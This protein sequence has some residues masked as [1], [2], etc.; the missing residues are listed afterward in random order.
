M[1]NKLF[2]SFI[3]SLIANPWPPGPLVPLPLDL[4][5]NTQKTCRGGCFLCWINSFLYD[6]VVTQIQDTVIGLGLFSSKY[7]CPGDCYFVCSIIVNECACDPIRQICVQ[8]QLVPRGI[9]AINQISWIKCSLIL[10]SISKT[11]DNI[12]ASSLSPFLIL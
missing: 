12:F 3:P 8:R 6:P 10:F 4:Q 1:A 5:V 2:N 9:G 11:V 7:S